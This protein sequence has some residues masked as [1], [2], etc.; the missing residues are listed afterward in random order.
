M[1]LDWAVLLIFL[2]IKKNN[3]EYITLEL[4]AL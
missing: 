4:A 1:M 3:Q 2:L